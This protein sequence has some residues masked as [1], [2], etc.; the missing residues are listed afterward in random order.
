MDKLAWIT[1]EPNT[2][3]QRY[4][5]PSAT[6]SEINRHFARVNWEKQR[7]SAAPAQS[8]VRPN[9]AR[10][11]RPF[12][13]GRCGPGSFSQDP[14]PGQSVVSRHPLEA[15]QDDEAPLAESSRSTDNLGGVHL[16][17][18]PP[19]RGARSDP[20]AVASVEI[21]TSVQIVFQYFLDYF[22]RFFFDRKP[23]AQCCHEPTPAAMRVVQSC[24]SDTARCYSLAAS[25]SAAMERRGEVSHEQPRPL[26]STVYTEKALRALRKQIADSTCNRMETLDTV[27][28]LGIGAVTLKNYHASLMHLRAAKELVDAESG[29]HAIEVLDAPLLQKIVQVDLGR[30]ICCLSPPVFSVP[31]R[32]PSNRIS[33][34][35]NDL[36]LDLE[37]QDVLRQLAETDHLEDMATTV[38]D[39][40]QAVQ[41]LAC[42]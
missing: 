32:P 36:L 38:G 41:M 14:W 29:L 22:N 4:A 15:G 30:A 24:S 17:C 12:L 3:A 11:D 39:M 1:T 13:R 34:L 37:V 35:D 42:S 25:V 20:F 19:V 27:I 28:I 31:H 9:A 21:D 18:Q 33:W 8:P 10:R 26:H 40:T 5:T 2:S 16:V 23:E 6:R 7:A